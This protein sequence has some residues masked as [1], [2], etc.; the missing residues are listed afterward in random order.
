MSG[1]RRGFESLGRH[2]VDMAAEEILQIDQKAHVG[3]KG[4]RAFEFHEE[5]NVAIGFGLV[6]RHRAKE[7]QGANGEAIDDLVPVGGDQGDDVGSAHACI[8][9]S[10]V[11]GEKAG[12]PSH[13]PRAWTHEWL[14]WQPV[15][16]TCGCQSPATRGS[17]AVQ[18]ETPLN[19]DVNRPEALR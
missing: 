9:P 18:E 5:I 1:R 13:P 4:G 7:R 8:I 3:V 2:D 6:A 16:V 15:N 14:R 17:V 12:T 10:R 19:D 11:A